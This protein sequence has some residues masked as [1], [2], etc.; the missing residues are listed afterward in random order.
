[1]EL[2]TLAE[3]ATVTAPALVLAAAFAVIVIV[4]VAF[5]ASVPSEQDTVVSQFPWLD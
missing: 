4:A 2:D 1:M 5:A 3:L